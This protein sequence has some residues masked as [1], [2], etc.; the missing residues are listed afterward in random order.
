[1]PNYAFFTMNV[2]WRLFWISKLQTEISL[3]ATKS[4][5]IALLNYMI[6]MLPSIKLLKETHESLN[7]GKKIIIALTN[8][9][10]QD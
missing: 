8:E 5:Y 2:G 3:S 9:W 4:E 1:M 6:E 7:F 10:F